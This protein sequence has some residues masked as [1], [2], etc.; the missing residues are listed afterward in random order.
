MNFGLTGFEQELI[1]AHQTAV[2]DEFPVC[3]PPM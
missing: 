3:L 1:R 2:N